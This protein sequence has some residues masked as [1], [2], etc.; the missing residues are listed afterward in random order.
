MK[1][2]KILQGTGGIRVVQ[3]VGDVLDVADEFLVEAPSGEAR[4]LWNILSIIRGDDFERAP[5]KDVITG[6][7]RSAIFPRVGELHR[8]GSLSSGNAMGA[9]FREVG[10]LDMTA[11]L[12]K[13]GTAHF[14][15][16]AYT[17]IRSLKHIKRLPQDRINPI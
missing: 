6:P 15:S 1:S 13:V 7:V 4:H 2:V 5:F 10:E 12:G 11:L 9:V 8:K 16:H 3:S 14:V 17:A